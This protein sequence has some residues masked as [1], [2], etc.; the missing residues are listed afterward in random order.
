MPSWMSEKLK[1][2]GASIF[3]TLGRVARERKCVNLGQGFPDFDGPEAV[4][5]AACQA[6]RDGHNQYAPL[7]G[8][9]PLTQALAEKYNEEAGLDFD[10]QTEITVLN[11]STEAMYAT[12]TALIEPGDE[13]IVFEPIYDTYLPV[14]QMN[15]GKVIAVP[16]QA[17]DFTFDADRL[18]AAFGDKTRAIIVNTPHNPTGRVFTAEEMGLIQKL[19]LQHDVICITDEVY[20]HLVFDDHKHIHMAALEG[21]RERTITISSTAKTF[22]L[23]GWKIG[24][25]LAPPKATE[26]IRRIHQFIAFAVATP[27]QHGI[28]AALRRRHQLIPQLAAEMAAKRS[29]LCDALADIGFNVTTPQGTFF[30]LA[31][32]SPFSDQKDLD[33]ALTLLESEVAVATIPISVFYQHQDEAPTNYLRFCFAKTDA[34]LQAGVAQLRRLN[35]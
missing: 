30:V 15:G 11:G 21:M 28:A 19:C 9:A 29:F 34:T 17:P 3:A 7:P 22:S 32:F 5:E 26:A 20:E 16:L 18:S 2:Y 10:P 1:P 6:I 24:Y 23:T 12:L 35:A 14:I 4:K 8:V 13:V 33:Y 27:L 31:D 25:T